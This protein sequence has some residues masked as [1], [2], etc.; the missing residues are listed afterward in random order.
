MVSRERIEKLSGLF[1][2]QNWRLAA[3]DHV[4][5]SPDGGYGVGG[6]N[7]T[8]HQ[9]VKEHTDGGQHLLDRR[10]GPRMVF[11]IGGNNNRLDVFERHLVGLTPLEKLRHCPA[12]GRPGVFVSNVGSKEFDSAPGGIGAGFG[13]RAGQVLEPSSRE[14]PAAIRGDFL[15]HADWANERIITEIMIPQCL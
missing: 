3:L 14:L 7:L 11:N 10:L 5:G 4:L 12:V 8:D 6:Y 1:G 13:D 9:I 2:P 15:G